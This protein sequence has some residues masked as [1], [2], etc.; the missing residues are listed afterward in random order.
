MRVYITFC[1]G[2]KDDSLKNSITAVPP[3]VLY[4]SKRIQAFMRRCKEK[5]VCWAILSDQY[6]VWFSHESHVWYE[7]HPDSVTEQ[8]FAALRAD[9]DNKL[10]TFDEICFCPG[11]GDTRI[12]SLYK[13]LL[14]ESKLKD[15]IVQRPYH[16][17]S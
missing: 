9:F 14:E 10:S 15:R 2:E 7:K 5:S 6:G 4:K 11:T 12:H 3:N 16:E 1:S 17:I 8:E 13:R